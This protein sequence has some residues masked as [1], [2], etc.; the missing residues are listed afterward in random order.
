MPGRLFYV[1]QEFLEVRNAQDQKSSPHK[2]SQRDRK[3]GIGNEKASEA[4]S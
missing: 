1:N 2:A 3:I 4:D